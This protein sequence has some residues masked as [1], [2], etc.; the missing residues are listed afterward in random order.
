MR[1]QLFFLLLI[2]TVAIAQIDQVG[3]RKDAN[4][5][6]GSDKST[7]AAKDLKATIDL[8]RIVTV[9]QDTTFVDTSLTI[10]DEYRMNYLRKDIFGLL[11]FANEG[12]TYQRL[13]YG[14]KKAE[15]YPGFGHTA[16]QY[17]YLEAGDI[18]YYS[19]AT[20]Y[21]DLY[22]R[23]VMEQGQNIDAFVSANTSPQFNFSIAYKGLRSL[24]K[25]I[26][27]LSSTG[28]FRFTAS[29]HTKSNRYAANFHFVSQDFLNNENGGI[30]NV[31]DFEG[32]SD[33]YDNRDRINV[34]FRDSKSFLRGKRLFLD[35]SF[36]V[37]PNDAQNNLFITHRFNHETKFFEFNQPTLT[38]ALDDGTVVQRFGDA[39]RTSGINDQTHYNRTYNRLGAVYENKTLGRFQFFTE[40]F[41]YN[42]FFDRVLVINNEVNSGLLSDEIQTV[43]GQYEYRKNNWQAT[44]LLSNSITNQS[45]SVVD[46][47]LRY[48]FDDRNKIS[49]QYQRMNKLPDH[50]YNMNQSSFVS[51]NWVNDF[52]NEKI[53]N[54]IIDA[55]TQWLTASAQI[56]S[57]TDMLYFSDD[58]PSVNVQLVTPKQYGENIKYLSVKVAREFKWWKLALDNTVLYQQTDQQQDIL[59]VPK[60][61]TRNTLYFTDTFFKKALFLQTGVT[62][63]YFTKYYMND[64]SPVLGEGFIQNQ[65]Q[66][67]EFPLFDFFLNARIKTARLYFKYEHFNS[68]W[69]GNNFLTAPNYPFR[70]AM[71]RFGMEWNF[72]K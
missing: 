4:T 43:G 42:Y 22:F 52:K 36:R 45:L 6:M 65:K 53:N 12:Q 26:N 15:A 64:Y 72:F 19:M 14:L 37:N 69:T 48:E 35:H 1:F 68:A 61:V 13:D 27:Q 41:R 16:K 8:Y 57:Y 58:D 34:Y 62:F 59:N 39:Y 67:G 66:I 51:Y 9:D 31:N 2:S 7:G 55:Q 3:P 33:R 47:N 50:I 18:R 71:I 56:S 21:T 60:I 44:L 29:Y 70:D 24:G 20:P 40:D 38:T 23:S 25:Y 11:P 10:Q 63:Q 28:N 32:G 46:G 30:T 54:I 17:A 5:P 49:F